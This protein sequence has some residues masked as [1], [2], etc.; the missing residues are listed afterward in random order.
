MCRPQ[1]LS[2]KTWSPGGRLLGSAHVHSPSGAIRMAFLEVLCFETS[3]LLL[4][5]LINIRWYLLFPFVVQVGMIS[6]VWTGNS[7]PCQAHSS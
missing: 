2:A 1:Y 6:L 5:I 4:I 3:T 7:S